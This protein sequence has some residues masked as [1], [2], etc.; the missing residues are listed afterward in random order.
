MGTHFHKGN[1]TKAQSTHHTP[2]NNSGSLQHTTLSNGQIIETQTKQ[3]H[4]ETN[5]NYELSESN[6]YL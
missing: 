2:Y 5:R 1:F 3:R 4:S 6:K